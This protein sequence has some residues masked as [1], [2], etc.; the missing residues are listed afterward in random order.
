MRVN[1]DYLRATSW[2]NST[3]PF[4]L[5]SVLAMGQPIESRLA[6]TAAVTWN[7]K[8]NDTELHMN[9][10]FFSKLSDEE[11]GAVLVHEAYH[12]L[13]RHLEEARDTNSF[14]RAR[15]C[16]FAQEAIINDRLT[17]AGYTLPENPITGEKI[18][19]VDCSEMTTEEVYELFC[20][21][22]P[23]DEEVPEFFHSSCS[24]TGSDER[25]DGVSRGVPANISS[26]EMSKIIE[27][28]ENAVKSAMKDGR[29]DSETAQEELPTVD[30]L[31]SAN[32]TVGDQI[33][34][35]SGY[36]TG[37]NAS[38]GKE[39]YEVSVEGTDRDFS[40]AFKEILTF[41]N[42]KM[43]QIHPEGD[44]KIRRNWGSPDRRFS[45]L[46]QKTGLFLPSTSVSDK[47]GGNLGK[48]A[49]VVIALDQSAS[50]PREFSKLLVEMAYQI[51]EE[52]FHYKAYTFSTVCL[53]FDPKSKDNVI[54]TGGTDFTDI[55]LKALEF[56][57]EIG[58]YPWVVVLTDGYAEF[59]YGESPS[60]EQFSKWV[61]VDFLASSYDSKPFTTYSNW[62]STFNF[63]REGARTFSLPMSNFV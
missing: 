43:G 42:P 48:K 41:I 19:G 62:N 45:Y 56:E 13:L 59:R 1:K 14:P 40:K 24:V 63:E 5:T 35:D 31:D 6:P 16:Y 8:T 17:G 10:E 22:F 57:R 26:F 23:E 46:G 3:H 29:F 11:A 61:A 60:G 18:V 21:K 28:V 49:N 20:Q 36:A 32:S 34:D 50:I 2:L 30:Q 47:K 54:A 12:I 25:S 9:K 51:P 53:S 27:K 55:H 37:V 44:Y 38:E 52:L 33:V 58:E 15:M 39:V 4:I 7:S